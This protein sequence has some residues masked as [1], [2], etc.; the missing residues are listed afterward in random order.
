MA[1]E[2]RHIYL[3]LTLVA[4]RWMITHQLD[5]LARQQMGLCSTKI[6]LSLSCLVYLILLILLI[7]RFDNV[8]FPNNVVYLYL[9]SLRYFP[10]TKC[11]GDV[12]NAL[13]SLSGF[14]GFISF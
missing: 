6:D 4:F 3:V 12:A 11:L 2:A 8:V 9:S 14:G 5:D 7:L 13:F 1:F 10:L